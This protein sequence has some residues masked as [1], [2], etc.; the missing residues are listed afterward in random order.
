MRKVFLGRQE[1]VLV[2]RAKLNRAPLNLI[3]CTHIP[4]LFSNVR[5]SGLFLSELASPKIITHSLTITFKPDK[6]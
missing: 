6:V 1:Q 5:K 4:L 2:C 3:R